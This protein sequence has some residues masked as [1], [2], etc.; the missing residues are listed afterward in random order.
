[1]RCC[2]CVAVCCDTYVSDG[3]FTGNVLLFQCCIF[4][5]CSPHFFL[6]RSIC[7]FIYLSLCQSLY[8]FIHMNAHIQVQPIADRVAQHLEIISKNVIF[9][10]SR[11]RILIGFIIY[12][13][14]L[15]VNP[16]DRILVR[17]K[18]FRHILEM[19]WPPICNRLYHY[20]RTYPYAWR[21]ICMYVYTYIHNMYIHTYIINVYIH[22]YIHRQI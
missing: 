16:M 11:T 1:V 5:F 20:T 4:F 8:L 18:S 6:S 14:V 22:T 17:W 7:I 2:V 10:T 12:Y 15:I 13:L 19:L 21:H 9:S 3:N